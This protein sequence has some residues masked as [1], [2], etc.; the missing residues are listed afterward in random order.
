MIVDHTKPARNYDTVTLSHLVETQP[1]KLPYNPA[2]NQAT[3]DDRGL[4]H[5]MGTHM[6]LHLSKT[7]GQI[8]T[9]FEALDHS[10]KM[11]DGEQVKKLADLSADLVT[12][13]MRYAN[14]YNFNLAESVVCR[15]EDKNRVTIPSW[16]VTPDT[17]IYVAPTLPPWGFEDREGRKVAKITMID[18]TTYV[19]DQKVPTVGF[20][21]P[22]KSDALMEREQLLAT[23]RQLIDQNISWTQRHKLAK[24]TLREATGEV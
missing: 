24:E 8:A 15:S 20:A 21:E 9:I 11:V 18:G 5:L 14:L 17:H 23:I 19:L 16:D 22:V 4:G 13:A 3:R 7:V 10:G 6:T 12:G 2:F 1:W